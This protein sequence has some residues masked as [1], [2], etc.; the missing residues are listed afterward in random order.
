[1]KNNG[2]PAKEPS[3]NM[4][5]CATKVQKPLQLALWI[6]SLSIARV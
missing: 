4:D 6:L 1:M 5:D 3:A 2:R